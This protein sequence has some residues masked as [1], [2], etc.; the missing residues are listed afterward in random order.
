MRGPHPPTGIDRD[1]D[2]IEQHASIT[3]R[4]GSLQ[5]ERFPR[6]RRQRRC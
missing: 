2:V 4:S 5:G 1:V 3:S 6:P